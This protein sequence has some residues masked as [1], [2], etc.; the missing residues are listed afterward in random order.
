MPDRLHTRLVE[1]LKADEGQP[2][3][4]AVI[5]IVYALLAP[6]WR[7][8]A[9]RIVTQLEQSR[10]A[11]APLDV[12]AGL[13]SIQIPF[14][15]APPASTLAAIRESARTLL[16]EA[17]QAAEQPLFLTTAAREQLAGSSL[18]GLLLGLEGRAAFAQSRALTALSVLT[19]RMGEAQRRIEGGAPVE[20]EE[21]RAAEADWRE[22]LAAA[23]D[24]DAS[25]LRAVV[26]GWAYRWS[27]LGIVHVTRLAGFQRLMVLNNPP[28]GP[29]SRTTPFC[30]YAHGRTIPIQQLGQQLDEHIAAVAT[31]SASAVAEQW[32]LLS[33]AEVEGGDFEALLSRVGMPPFH[34]GCRNVL[35]PVFGPAT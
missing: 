9:E 10:R 25:R 15:T 21:L 35:R 11:G 19:A 30:A 8:E 2:E 26:E 20:L 1:F 17:A 24:S 22:A 16:E 13:I 4:E 14:R 7:A 3:V 34:F 23:V 29:D 32:P 27:N 12:L 33:R 5:A 6:W 18:Q 28:L 31:G